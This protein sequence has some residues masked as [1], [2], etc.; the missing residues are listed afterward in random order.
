MISIARAVRAGISIFGL[1]D[2]IQRARENHG[3][4]SLLDPAR[5][6]IVRPVIRQGRLRGPFRP[7][8]AGIRISQSTS[9]VLEALVMEGFEHGVVMGQETS[10]ALIRRV[11]SRNDAE[12]PIDRR[13]RPAPFFDNR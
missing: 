13:W 9:P 3:Y 2:N 4:D 8:S 1:A 11:A 10:K 5:P 7:E 6:G 12:R